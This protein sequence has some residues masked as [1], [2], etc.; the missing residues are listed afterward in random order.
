[1]SSN[2]LGIPIF[3]MDITTQDSVPWTYCE[4]VEQIQSIRVEVYE[5]ISAKLLCDAVYYE[6]SY[7]GK[8]NCIQFHLRFLIFTSPENE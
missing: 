6:M 8:E 2:V 3:F 5:Q 4:I 7:T 1:M